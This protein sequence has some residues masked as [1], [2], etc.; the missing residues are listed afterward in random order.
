MDKSTTDPALLLAEIERLERECVHLQGSDRELGLVRG[1]LD[2]TEQKYRMAFEYTGTAMMV[3]EADLTISMGNHRMEE[4]TGYTQAELIK[5]RP[6]TDYVFEEDHGKMLEFHQA[7]R[8][9]GE[10]VPTQYEFRLRHR[11]GHLLD[12]AGNIS[13]IPGTEKT[14][15]SLI[16]ITE[17]KRMAKEVRERERQYRDL[18]EN[19]NDIIYVHDFDGNFI[20]VNQAGLR[21]FQYTSEQIKKINIREIVDSE[22]LSVALGHIKDKLSHET[23]SEP[24]ELLTYTAGREPVW[25][26]VNTRMIVQ[27]GKPVGVQGVARD[28][29]ERKRSEQELRN[30]E[31]RFKE[32]AELLPG[33]ICEIDLSLTITYVNQLGFKIFGYPQE[34]LGK[35]IKVLDLFGASERER[36]AANAAKILGGK[37]VG[38]QEY[39]MLHADGTERWYLVS[40]SPMRNSDGAVCGLRTTLL[41]IDELRSAQLRVAESEARFR[42][43]FNRSPI[44]IAVFAQSGELVECNDSFKTLFQSEARGDLF[45]LSGISDAQSKQLAGGEGVVCEGGSGNRGENLGQG[46]SYYDWHIT[47]VTKSDSAPPVYLAQVQNVTER[48]RAHNA[49]VARAREETEKANRLIEDLK[50]EMRETFTFKNMVSRSPEMRRIFDILPEIAQTPTTVLVCGDSGTGKELIA[51]SVHELSPRMSRPFVAINCGALPDNLLESELFG[52]KAGAFT[53]AKKDKPGKFSLAEG[54][55]L[56]LDEIGDISPAM[57]VKLLR[58]LQERV[59]EP[60]GAAASVRADVRVVAATNRDLA[61]MVK[62][63]QFRKDLYYRINVLQ[64]KL[65]PLRERRCDIPLLCEYMIDQFNRRYGKSIA[66]I[67]SDALAVLLSHDF[68]GN[69]R[70]LENVIEHAFVFCKEAEIQVR[71]LPLELGQ[72]APQTSGDLFSKINSFDELE[73]LYIQSVLAETGGNKLRAAEKLGVHKATLFRKLKRLGVGGNNCFSNSRENGRI[74]V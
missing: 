2:E 45:A 20:S 52:Y 13:M 71:H 22:Y 74:G 1:A 58:V 39:R 27:E 4:I 72:T 33:I 53:D 10:T 6:W 26:E 55:T 56:F 67:G 68:P 17:Q 63:G 5:K 40:S 73:R 29:T 43:I 31:K 24:Y 36:A 9:H 41:E 37:V 64:V 48:V 28:V 8:E 50:K 19:A 44:G 15:V 30:S 61:A 60:L 25:V 49:T 46:G 51:R 65:P 16:D 11:D 32:T 57:Q 7:R 23:A 69:V 59:Y 62:S 38:P 3:V 42:S 34:M 12:V 54:G 35:G 21:A 66:G 14:L 18:F 70:E 47:P